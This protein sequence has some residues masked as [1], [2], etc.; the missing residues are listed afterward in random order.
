MVRF[1]LWSLG[2]QDSDTKIEF[3]NVNLCFSKIRDNHIYIYIYIYIYRH[4]ILGVSV[5][6]RNG[7]KKKK[8]TVMTAGLTN[9]TVM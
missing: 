8:L 5:T 6:R 1:E 2:H 9:I 4:T 7:Y 3:E